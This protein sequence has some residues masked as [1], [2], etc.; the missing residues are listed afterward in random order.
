MVTAAGFFGKLPAHGDFVDRGWPPAAIAAWDAW[1]Q[2]AL[3]QS[4]GQLGEQW[5][6]IY[7][8]SPLWRFGLSAGCIDSNPWL[9]ILLPSVDRVGRYF[10]LLLGCALD[11]DCHLTRTFL[12][13]GDWFTAL[14]RIGFA[15]LERT[16]AA[17]ELER[18]LRELAPPP[19]QG[20]PQG[21]D[22]S[23][24]IYCAGD[25]TTALPEL[26]EWQWRH[27][28]PLSLWN[29]AGSERVQ[30]GLLCARGL[31]PP[32]A[33]AAMLDGQWRQRGWNLCAT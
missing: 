5:L 24:G 33:F 16:L 25:S 1:L 13:A 19:L 28:G 18:Q 29:S 14:E 27:D 4:R 26:L 9:G 3:A 7:L 21:G 17:D 20:A 10:P 31:P 2:Q 22:Q 11:G 15:A 6:D 8:T 23:T 32:S 12:G 30:P